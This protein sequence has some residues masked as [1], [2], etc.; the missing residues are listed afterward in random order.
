MEKVR[1]DP[2]VIKGIIFDFNGTMFQDSDLHE[3]AWIKMIKHYAQGNISEKEILKNIHGRTNDE[4][5]STFIAN[6]LSVEEVIALGTEKESYYRKLCIQNKQRLVLTSGLTEILNKIKKIK[7]PMTIA[8][9]T[10][11]ENVDFYFEKFQLEQWFDYQQVVYDD[12]TFPGKP[13]PDIFIKAADALTVPPDKCL[14]FEDSY[15]G[16]IAASRAGIG[17]LVAIDNTGKLKEIL[18]ESIFPITA[19][20]S[21]F[22]SVELV[23]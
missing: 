6:D 11:K 4:I 22:Y 23:C 16:I 10:T 7:I 8:T 13:A 1:V 14:V 20:I 15:S 12:G 21:D 19:T 2:S 9:A 3:A 5:I 17:V 18:D